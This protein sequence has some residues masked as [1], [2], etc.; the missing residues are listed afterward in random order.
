MIGVIDY[1]AGNAEYLIGLFDQLGY[2]SR[3]ILKPQ[4]ISLCSK[5]IFPGVA[6]V[7]FV[8]E[9]LKKE[10][11]LN[12]I[13]EFKER[14]NPILGICAGMQLFFEETEES[15]LPTLGMLKGKVAKIQRNNHL[16]VPNMGWREIEF[17]NNHSTLANSTFKYEAYFNHSYAFQLNESL[18]TAVLKDS[19][20]ISAVVEFE[21]IMGVQ[22]HPEK[23]SKFG[24]EVL[25]NFAKK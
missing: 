1:Q 4:D 22:F 20:A 23:S 9:F 10:D 6:N 15:T 12:R 21:N 13:F 14:G 25:N 2:R 3:L 11:W 8:L 18:T 19:P 17:M 7:N 5:I 16:N 24:L